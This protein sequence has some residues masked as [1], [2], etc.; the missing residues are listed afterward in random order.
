MNYQHAIPLLESAR[1]ILITAHVRPDG[2][3]VGSVAALK[4][5]IEQAPG[6][7]VQDGSVDMLFLGPVPEVYQF[8]LPGPALI[9]G[10][11][12]TGE[13][14]EAGALDRYDWMVVVDTRAVRQLPGIGEYLQK[15]Q[16]EVLVIDHHLAGDEI[17]TVRLIDSGACAAGE[18]VYELIRQGGWPMDRRVAAALLVAIGTDTGWFRFENASPRAFRIA[19]ELIEAGAAADE[20]Y[21]KLF[22]NDPPERLRLLALTL[23]TLELDTT[24]RLAVM[25][26]TKDMLERS[27]ASRSHVENIVNMPQQIGTVIVTALLV[28]EE[29]G[30]TRCS[31]RS[32]STVDVNAVAQQFG[33]GGHAR[34]AGLTMPD[35]LT[36]ART[37]MIAVLNRELQKYR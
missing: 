18:L 28:E 26:I 8:V 10:H 31:L 7:R 20:I 22:Q 27:G 11:D 1:K 19:A 2:D 23:D 6:R 4:L 21:Q 12:M 34:A 36:E 9:W 16:K 14:V 3:A 30:G 33:G 24:G 35:G 13:Q 37:K 29:D 5:A 25:H 17:G 15:R 32:K